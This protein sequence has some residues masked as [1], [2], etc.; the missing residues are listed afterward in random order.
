MKLRMKHELLENEQEVE[1]HRSVASLHTPPGSF[2]IGSVSRGFRSKSMSCP[3]YLH[4]EV[5]QAPTLE[6]AE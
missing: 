4:I 1:A 2:P 6:L 3:A 5:P